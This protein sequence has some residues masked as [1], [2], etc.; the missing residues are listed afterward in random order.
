[1]TER[2]VGC[3]VLRIAALDAQ[4][5]KSF[6]ELTC[7]T[8]LRFAMRSRTESAASP[9]APIAF[10]RVNPFDSTPCD[11]AMPIASAHASTMRYFACG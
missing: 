4:F 7:S 8:V 1:M 5:G 11:I 6:V 10:F 3:A 2:G 9:P